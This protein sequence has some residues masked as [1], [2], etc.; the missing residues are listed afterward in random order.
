MRGVSRGQNERG[1]GTTLRAVPEVLADAPL[2][3]RTT[4]RLGG[5]ARR[6]IEAA[7]EEELARLVRDADAA[8]EPVLVLAGGSNV[9][10]ADAGFAGTVG[11]VATR[12]V[13]RD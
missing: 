8:G 5:P 1:P 2:A 3:P 12:G 11:Q 9:V 7:T 10:I 6:L 4:L 13:E